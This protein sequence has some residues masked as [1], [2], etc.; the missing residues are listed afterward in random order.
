MV[1]E[2]LR[3]SYAFVIPPVL[4]FF[5][6][7][8]LCLLSFLRGPRRST[9]ILF[10][11]MC[12]LGALINL[13]V[14]LVSILSDKTLALKLDR[15]IYVFFVFSPPIYIQF[16]HAFLRLKNRRWLETGAYFM[17]AVFLFF[18]FSDLF[19]SGFHEY[20]FGTIARAG[21]VFHVFSVLSFFTV[22]YCLLNTFWEA[23]GSVPCSLR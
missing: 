12:L 11:G 2:Y 16:V 8:S 18:V 15:M 5:V 7:T 1:V 20:A 17:S 19:I 6:L 10:A 13:D 14:A 4:G 3:T 21:P 22:F 23:W 9:N